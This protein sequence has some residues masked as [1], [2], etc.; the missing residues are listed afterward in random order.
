MVEAIQDQQR[1]QSLLERRYAVQVGMVTP[2]ESE[3]QGIGTSVMAVH[4]FL[5]N[6]LKFY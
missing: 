4:K 1:A 6:F 3:S 2:E 5:S